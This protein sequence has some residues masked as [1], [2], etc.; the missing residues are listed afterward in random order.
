MECPDI[1]NLPDGNA[2]FDDDPYLNMHEKEIKR[3]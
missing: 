3:R 1:V 2:I